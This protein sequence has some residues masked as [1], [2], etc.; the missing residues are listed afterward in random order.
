M[1]KIT[2]GEVF[3]MFPALLEFAQ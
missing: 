2:S 3:V 1:S